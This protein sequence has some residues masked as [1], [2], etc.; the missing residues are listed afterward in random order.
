M[1]IIW[2]SP[3]LCDSNGATKWA[4]ITRSFLMTDW[5]AVAVAIEMNVVAT[6]VAQDASKPYKLDWLTLDPIRSVRPKL[7]Q[8]SIISWIE[9]I[10]RSTWKGHFVARKPVCKLR[11]SWN[12]LHNYNHWPCPGCKWLMLFLASSIASTW[13]KLLC[14]NPKKRFFSDLFVLLTIMWWFPVAHKQSCNKIQRRT[15]NKINNISQKVEHD[16][17]WLKAISLVIF[18]RSFLLLLLCF[19]FAFVLVL[20]EH[21]TLFVVSSTS[22]RAK[23]AASAQWIECVCVCVRSSTLW[24]KE[25]QTKLKTLKICRLSFCC[26]RLHALLQYIFF[27]AYFSNG[28]SIRI[29]FCVGNVIFR[30]VSAFRFHS[31]HSVSFSVQILMHWLHHVSRKCHQWSTGFVLF[32]RAWN[33]F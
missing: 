22:R 7:F 10:P 25:E 14:N 13:R 28:I 11:I 29:W 1:C 26:T 9:I 31:W 2:R 21:V 33:P 20:L 32:S 27:L 3:I 15:I 5:I 8:F 4:I 23:F 30:H 24:I 19:C 6:A 16:S 18:P 12:L 17:K